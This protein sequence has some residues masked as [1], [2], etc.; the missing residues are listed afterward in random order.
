MLRRF[1]HTCHLS[2]LKWKQGES[3]ALGTARIP[4]ERLIPLFDMPPAGDFDHEKQRP[5]SP[6]EHIRLF[7]RRLRERW[8]RRVA[9]VDAIMIDDELH[10]QG[11]ANHPLTELLERARLAQALALPVTGIGRSEDYQ[12]AIRRFV[13]NSPGL[14]ICFRVTSADLDSGTFTADITAL[15]AELKCKPPET[16]FVMDFKG[17]SS[18]SDAAIDDFVALLR[19]RIS[20][21]PF[22][23]RWLGLAVVLSSFPASIKLEAGEVKAYPRT[24][25][26][27]YG[28]L[29]MNP[30]GLL[31]IPMF[32]DYA[33]D[34]SSNDKP[35]RRTPSAHLRYSTPASYIVS[36]GHS[37]K[38]PHG[39]QAIYPVADAL[40]AKPGFMGPSY[41]A[42][43]QFIS[44]LANRARGTGNAATWRWASTDHHL[45]MNFR[46]LNS[47]FGIV[48]PETAKS[49]DPAAAQGFLF[50][51][52]ASPPT[53]PADLSNEL[54]QPGAKGP[55]EVT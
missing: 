52:L 38:K 54:A 19:D 2:I 4:P 23:H 8:G 15:V 51:D 34:T 30:K 24:D 47:F 35:Q 7:G 12:R 49:A 18:F 28:R 41:S 39:Y 3:T 6:T 20:E 33:V 14:P 29:L 40:I 26:L 48:E 55:R 5:L 10:K 22:L 1:D 44:Q 9:F 27:A 45:T 13:D 53:A 37:V 32:G 42:G 11:R 21:L 16:F 31:R 17:Q 25:L 50:A 46:A 43:D 36:K